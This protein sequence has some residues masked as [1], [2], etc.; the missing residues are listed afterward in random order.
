MSEPIKPSVCICS[1]VRK[2]K[3][4]KMF[5]FLRKTNNIFSNFLQNLNKTCIT[6]GVIVEPLYSI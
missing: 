6:E 2:L 4:L 1:T 3:H 5:L